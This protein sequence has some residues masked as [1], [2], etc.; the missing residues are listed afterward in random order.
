MNSTRLSVL[1]GLLL[2]LAACAT[3]TPVSA[4]PI[5]ASTLVMVPC[6]IQIPQ[7][8]PFAVDTLP[9]GASIW[10]QMAALRAERLQRIGYIEELKAAVKGCQ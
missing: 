7:R 6:K 8:T 3:T 5:E 9:I 10:D 2:L 1:S 4:T